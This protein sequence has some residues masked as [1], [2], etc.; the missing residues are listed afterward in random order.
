[1]KLTTEQE[2]RITNFVDSQGLKIQTLR[3]DVIDH[4]CC[5]VESELGK[6]KS[7]EQLLDKA[8][9]DLAPNGLIEIQHKT[10]FLLNSKRILMMKKLMYL[11]GFIGSI[12]LTA[13]VTFKLLRIPFGT[14]LFTVGFL[15]LLLIF[16]PLIA[17]DRYKVSLSKAISVK[18][19]L[20][21]GV[22]AAVVAGLSGLFKLMHLQGAD[23]LLML[24]AFVFAFGFLPFY[25]F[26]MYKKSVS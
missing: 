1:M 5:V 23:L 3:D 25:F 8:I 24:G 12:T 19:K 2:N 7:F 4:L 26:T 20:I 11:I 22:V 14:E 17:I 10:I 13:G 9:M 6:G 21:L 16:I 18:L 15:T